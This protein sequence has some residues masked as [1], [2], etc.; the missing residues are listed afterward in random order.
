MSIQHICLLLGFLLTQLAASAQ[1]PVFDTIPD[2][3][4]ENTFPPIIQPDLQ[5]MDEAQKKKK[6]TKKPR[7]FIPDPKKAVILSAIFPGNGQIYNRRYW[8]LPIVY[9]AVGGMTY[10]VYTNTQEHKRFKRAFFLRTDGD[11]TTIDEFDGIFSESDL[12]NLRQ[13]ARS[14]LELAY[15]GLFVAY[16]LTGVEAFVDA[17]L[18]SFDISDDLSFKIKPG[19][20]A[21][22]PTLG[23]SLDF[24]GRK[25][26]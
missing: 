17:H 2:T 23:A 10:L 24:G 1:E 14:N 20:S 21:F 15:V 12:S 4:P 9:G 18:Q 16:T 19:I 22:G 26:R 6:K 3:R 7:T 5:A 13:N 11:E 25:T 8:K